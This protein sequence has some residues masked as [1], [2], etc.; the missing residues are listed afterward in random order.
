MICHLI[1]QTT[2][3][4]FV[5]ES[6][7]RLVDLQLVELR[8]AKHESKPPKLYNMWHSQSKGPTWP[9]LISGIQAKTPEIGCKSRKKC[10]C[11]GITLGKGALLQIQS[12]LMYEST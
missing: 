2:S 10:L 6:S 3:L 8:C 7:G 9:I 11:I 12:V 1:S 4:T 5:D